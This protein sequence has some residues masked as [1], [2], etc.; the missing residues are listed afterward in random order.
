MTRSLA[1]AREA[2]R[3]DPKRWRACLY[4]A[5]GTPLTA[6]EDTRVHLYCLVQTARE[7]LRERL[8]DLEADGWKRSK[9][10]R[11]GDGI[12]KLERGQDVLWLALDKRRG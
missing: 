10:Y 7:K 6:R 2:V 5:T 4:E 3:A 9:Q 12:A 11:L 8:A 1:E